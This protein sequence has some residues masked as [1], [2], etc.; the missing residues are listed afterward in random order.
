MTV[1]S[2]VSLL[3]MVA[4]VGASL[5]GCAGSTA[6]S[7]KMPSTQ[8]PITSVSAV[9]GKW[10]GTVRRDPSIEDDWADLTIKDDGT[11]EVKSFRTI[12]AILGGGRLTDSNGQL[13]SA[14]DRASSTLTLY[15]GD[16]KR[17]LKIDGTLKNGVT[18]SGWLTP[19][20]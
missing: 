1:R 12:G 3:L 14:T 19:A 15:E 9:A 18:F 20:K 17:V 2:G 7:S 8:V 6:S 4:L 5:A 10:A 13:T 11:Y 16:G